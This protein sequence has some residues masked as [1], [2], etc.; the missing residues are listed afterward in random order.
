VRQP[1]PRSRKPASETR[2]RLLAVAVDR[3]KA[4]GLLLDYS[5]IELEDLI[6][7]AGVPRSTVFRIW[8]DR[9]A[10]VADLV[11]ALFEADPGFESGFDGETLELLRAALGQP[12]DENRSEEDRQVA[13]RSVI[14]IG[15]AHNIV[16]VD[17]SVAWR[18]YRTMSAALAS[19]DAVP[20]GEEIRA[21][22]S[23]IED[24][25]V[26]RMA[27]MYR[28]L[29]EA[30]GLRMCAGVTER[31][32]ALAIMSVIDGMSDHRRINPPFTDRP[33]AVSLGSDAAQ[34]WHLAALAV[35]GVYSCF[36]EPA[37]RSEG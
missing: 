4:E 29:N 24:A 1:E 27:E 21:L 22:L 19:G 7:V 17:S 34:D 11:R 20:G 12:G 16:A 13:L 26:E 37:K 35:Y 33:R 28:R 18:A 15:V 14:R 5:N 3:V 31:D 36:T 30:I 25:Y 8:P 32:L 23:E 6:R 10:F 2:A 9:V